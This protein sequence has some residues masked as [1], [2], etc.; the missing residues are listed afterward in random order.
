MAENSNLSSSRSDK[1]DE[2][3]TQLSLIKSELKHYKRHFKG[4][5]VLCNS[6]DPFESNF[7]KY[8]AMNF[9]SLGLKKLIATCYATSSIIYTQWT[10]FGNE[11]VAGQEPSKKKPYRI[12]IARFFHY[13]QILR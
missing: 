12:E 1:A 11:V 7:F 9:N 10:L 13:P 3:Y 2:F 6:D 8:F 5:V 4:K